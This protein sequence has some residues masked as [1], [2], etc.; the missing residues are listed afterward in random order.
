MDS[1]S[2]VHSNFLDKRKLIALKTKAIRSGAWFKTLKRI[3]RA[4]IDLTIKVVELIKS[5][6]LAK[7]ILS[8]TRKLEETLKNNSF[9]VR[10]R[11]IGLHLAKKISN[12]AQKLGNLYAAAWA[13]DFSFAAFLTAIHINNLKIFKG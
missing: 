12:I 6:T 3:D 1:T 11:E 13:F 7:S 10:L 2:N 9:S 4:L 5:E 8:L